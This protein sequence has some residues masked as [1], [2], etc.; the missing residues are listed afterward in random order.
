MITL[1]FA[2]TVVLI[3][4][5]VALHFY[6]MT[7]ILGNIASSEFTDST[8]Y[9]VSQLTHAASAAIIQNLGQSNVNSEMGWLQATQA[10]VHC[11]QMQCYRKPSKYQSNQEKCQLGTAASLSELQCL[12]YFLLSCFLRM[13]RPPTLKVVTLSMTRSQAYQ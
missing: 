6:G 7:V 1:S 5:I 8:K 3:E 10:P 13:S 2:G 11:I 4:E 9:Q 12:M